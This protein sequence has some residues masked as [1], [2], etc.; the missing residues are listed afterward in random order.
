MN[1][2][3]LS[4]DLMHLASIFILLAKIRQ[5]RSCVGEF[6]LYAKNKSALFSREINIKL[7]T[8]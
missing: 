2:F 3:R 5:S 1:I 4:A 7:L 6:T 8:P